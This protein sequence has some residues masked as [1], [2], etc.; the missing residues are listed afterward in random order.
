M[1]SEGSW[2]GRQVV[3]A[4]WIRESVTPHMTTDRTE[5]YGYLWWLTEF[6]R[7][8]GLEPMVLANGHG[9]Q[10]IAWLPQRDVVLVVTG[11]NEDNGKHFAVLEVLA[12]YL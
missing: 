12:Q 10:F 4:D 3:S 11:G 2:Q 9:S 6:P 7:R 5:K 8:E 1:R